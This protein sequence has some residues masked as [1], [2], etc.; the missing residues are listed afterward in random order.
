MKPAFLQVSFNGS[1]FCYC[2]KL[3][4]NLL[5][6]C[7]FATFDPLRFWYNQFVA[8]RV[9]AVWSRWAMKQATILSHLE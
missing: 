7:G 3:L 2:N 1:N 6:M 4:K 8:I 9:G 5:E